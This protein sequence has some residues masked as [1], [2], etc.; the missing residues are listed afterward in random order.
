MKIR[1][2]PEFA[3]IE[4]N[5][6]GKCSQIVVEYPIQYLVGERVVT[7]AEQLHADFCFHHQG[8]AL[9]YFIEALPKRLQFLTTR[10]TPEAPN[11]GLGG[12]DV[13]KLGS[14]LVNEDKR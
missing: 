14:G 8:R 6:S 4:R 11:L 13:W 10:R 3:F 9:G 5:A 12:N 7:A 1:L 2:N